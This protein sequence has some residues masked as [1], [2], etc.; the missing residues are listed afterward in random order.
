VITLA[1]E[2]VPAD[3]AH[4]PVLVSGG[5]NPAADATATVRSCP[6]V[7]LGVV[8]LWASI[9]FASEIV[10]SVTPAAQRNE[11]VCSVYVGPLVG[12]SATEAPAYVL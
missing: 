10:L 3:V 5:S 2:T 7:L 4:D 11:L 9:L 6:T 12:L 8:P 1:V